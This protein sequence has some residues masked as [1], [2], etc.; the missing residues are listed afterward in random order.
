MANETLSIGGEK[1]REYIKKYP[2]ASTSSIA[3]KLAHDF[4]LLFN[5]SSARALV[6]YHTNKLR[7]GKWR[8][9]RN[10]IEKE[11][12]HTRENPY[13]L[14]ESDYED[15]SPFIIPPSVKDLLIGSDFHFLFQDNKAISTWIDY[16]IGQNP[17]GIL[18]NGDVMDCYSVSAYD[19]NPNKGRIRDEFE[20]VRFFLKTLRNKFP[21]IP[22]YFKEGNHEERWE[23]NLRV[24]APVLLDMDEFKLDVILRLGEF[25]IE[26]IKDK[27]II[28]Y[29][30]LNII[31]GHEIPFSSSANGARSLWLKTGES[32]LASHVHQT[33][34]NLF[35]KKGSGDVAGCWTIGCLCGLNPD[36]AKRSNNYMHGF[37]HV[38]KDGDY[39]S[40]KNFQMIDYKVL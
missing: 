33:T 36:Y 4:P 20:A 8:K 9:C 39:F 27:R 21:N 35:K 1:T 6:R 19:K 16:G 32:F 13:G 11:G 2:N 34:S 37:A 17:S 25:G 28:K 7:S 3:R 40:V 5:E 12:A 22:I 23:R 26:Y 14:A 18:L 10:P 15:Q 31:H 38:F 29:S 30:G 24:N